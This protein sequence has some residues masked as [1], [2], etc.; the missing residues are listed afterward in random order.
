MVLVKNK[1]RIVTI[2]VMKMVMRRVTIMVMGMVMKIVMRIVRK[3]VMKMV[4]IIDGQ[5]VH[6]R[7]RGDATVFR[8]G[9]HAILE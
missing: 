4:R 8:G 5:Q 2:M 9:H 6:Y 7:N 3:M 1:I